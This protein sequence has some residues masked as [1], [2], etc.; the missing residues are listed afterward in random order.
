MAAPVVLRR[1]TPPG[2]HVGRLRARGGPAKVAL[3]AG[4]RKLLT[5][6]SAVTK[7]ERPCRAAEG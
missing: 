1:G 6:P 5:T 7:A 3:A 4:M 2:A